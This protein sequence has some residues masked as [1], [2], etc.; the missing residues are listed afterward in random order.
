MVLGW[1]G[2]VWEGLGRVGRGGE[3]WGGPRVTGG[4]YFLHIFSGFAI[5]RSKKVYKTI[6]PPAQIKFYQVLGQT[7]QDRAELATLESPPEVSLNNSF[8]SGKSIF[9]PHNFSFS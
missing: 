3:G 9:T 5:D 4:G 2:R 7:S 8:K 6:P 1:F